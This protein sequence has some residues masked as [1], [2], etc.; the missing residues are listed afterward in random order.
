MG[1]SDLLKNNGSPTLMASHSLLAHASLSKTLTRSTTVT[2]ATMR[3]EILS[4]LAFTATLSSAHFQILYPPQGYEFSE[5]EQTT[6]PCGGPIP[7]VNGETVD[8][9][10][11]QFAISVRSGHPKGA[12]SFSYTNSTSEPLN[13]TEISTLEVQGVGD[14]CLTSFSVP[15]ELAGSSG[16]V[17]VV[18][19]A[20]DGMLYQ[21]EQPSRQ[22]SLISLTRDKVLPSELRRG[23]E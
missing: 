3:V 14:F 10:V 17:Q 11:D 22:D 7:E 12:W 6:G 5:E 9:Q 23:S 13:F 19:N 20:E 15:S 4:T 8:V 18:N 21:V 1:K 16:I 2:L